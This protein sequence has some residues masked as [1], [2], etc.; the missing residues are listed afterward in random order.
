MTK[1]EIIDKAVDALESWRSQR[2]IVEE[3]MDEWAGQMI[4]CS[5][6]ITHTYNVPKYILDE[7]AKQQILAFLVFRE[8][9][10]MQEE[11]N[12]IIACERL[13]GPFTF[14]RDCDEAIYY[15]FIKQ[16]P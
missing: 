5:T 14:T 10:K 2:D 7:Y 8:Q 11:V 15:K 12:Y 13:G 1:E 4:A 9:Y 3:A 6:S 16:Q